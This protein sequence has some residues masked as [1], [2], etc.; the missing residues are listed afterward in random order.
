VLVEVRISDE[1]F[2]TLCKFHLD[3]KNFR[4]LKSKSRVIVDSCQMLLA[5]LGVQPLPPQEA[6]DAISSVFDNTVLGIHKKDSVLKEI[7]DALNEVE[8]S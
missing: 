6:A 5:H 2:G 4:S 1:L 8:D 7:E 3:N